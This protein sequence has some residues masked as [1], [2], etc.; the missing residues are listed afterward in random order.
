MIW[1]PEDR[2]ANLV[3]WVVLLGAIAAWVVVTLAVRR[4]P[5]VADVTAF[6]RR[7]WI[8]R[9]AALAFWVWLGWHLFV[10]TTA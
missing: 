7:W 6:V 5:S 1:L 10:R 9:W 4:L 3:L 2:T 8:L